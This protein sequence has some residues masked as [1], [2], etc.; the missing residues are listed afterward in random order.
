MAKLVVR[1][2]LKIP[3]PVKAVWV[4]VPPGAPK[5]KNMSILSGNIESDIDLEVWYSQ[6]LLPRIEW[7]EDV[8]LRY[9]SPQQAC[10][11]EMA[12]QLTKDINKRIVARIFDS[13]VVKGMDV[14]DILHKNDY[15]GRQNL[16]LGDDRGFK[17][18]NRRNPRAGP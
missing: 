3:W 16:L 1:G 14:V 9:V 4:R 15:N 11:D 5:Q 17:G 12:D 18:W 2:G 6:E 13:V 7:Y 8:W 10:I